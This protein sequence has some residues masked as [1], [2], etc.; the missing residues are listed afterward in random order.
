MTPPD[1]GEI[2]KAACDGV[3]AATELRPEYSVKSGKLLRTFCNIGARRV[4]QA[5]G[6]HDFDDTDLNADAMHALMLA[7]WKK[8]DSR[9]AVLHALDGGLAFASM[10]GK[11]LGDEHGHI[12]AVRPEARQRSGSLGVDVPMVANVGKGDPDA[13]MLPGAQTGIKTKRNWNCKSSQAFPVSKGE[14]DYFIKA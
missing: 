5:M 13:P 2:L 10:T 8:V 1:P 7:K 3:V 12:A 14:P 6:C 11:Q 9:E 4:A